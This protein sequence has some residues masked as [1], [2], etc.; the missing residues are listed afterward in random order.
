[1]MILNICGFGNG[2]STGLRRHTGKLRLYRK[3]R[4]RGITEFQ[5]STRL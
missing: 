4:G 1:M 3:R 5:F 2:I